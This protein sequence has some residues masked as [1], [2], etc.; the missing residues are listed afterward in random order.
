MEIEM[1]KTISYI[2]LSCAIM[3]TSNAWAE[4]TDESKKSELLSAQIA[5]RNMVKRYSDNTS[6]INELKKQQQSAQQRLQSAQAELASLE[7]QIATLQAEQQEADQQLRD[8]G[9][10]LDNAWSAVKE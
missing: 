6:K 5:Y 8:M 10:R 9:T 7:Q 4:S 1:K 2:L 3:L